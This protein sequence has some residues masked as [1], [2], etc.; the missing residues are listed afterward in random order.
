MDKRKSMSNP[1]ADILM[2]IA[3]N[4]ADVPSGYVDM[5]D[6]IISKIKERRVRFVVQ[7]NRGM[8][9]LYWEI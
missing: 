9:E 3:P 5:R 8:I 2:P 7:V 6:M 4:L 1:H